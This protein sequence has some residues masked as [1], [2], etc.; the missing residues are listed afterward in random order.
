VSSVNQKDSLK[1]CSPVSG[2][3]V[4][5]LACVSRCDERSDCTLEARL[6]EFVEDPCPNTEKYLEAHYICGSKADFLQESTTTTTPSLNPLPPWLTTKSS[7]PFYPDMFD[8]EITPP[9]RRVPITAKPLEKDTTILDSETTTEIPSTT[10][11][12][13][14]TTTFAPSTTTVLVETT[15]QTLDNS[16]SSKNETSQAKI[17]KNV[18]NQTKVESNGSEKYRYSAE[19]TTN[20]TVKIV[21]STLSPKFP[22]ISPETGKPSH[23]RSDNPPVQPGK[24]SPHT[25]TNMSI[26]EHCQPRKIRALTWEW[27]VAGSEAVLECPQGTT[28]LATWKC[29]SVTSDMGTTA[30]WETPSPNL[31]QCESFW[32]TKIQEDLKRSGNIVNIAQDMVQYIAANALYGGDIKSAINAIGI[33]AEKMHFQ[34]TNIPTQEQKEAVVM[35]LV[36]SVIK[37]ASIL[38]SEHMLPA[39][40]DL[41]QDVQMKFLS[42]FMRALENTG[43]LLPKAVTRDQEASISSQNILLSVKKISFRNIIRTHF[44]SRAARATRDWQDYQDSIEI[45]ALVL[46]ENMKNDVAEI[47]FLSFKNLEH[48][49]LPTNIERVIAGKEGQVLE[50][51]HRVV[52]SQVILAS[53]G[54]QKQGVVVNEPITMLFQHKSTKNVT[55]PKCVYWD[56][57]RN[58]WSGYGCSLLFTNSSHSQCSCD[59]HLSSYALVDEVEVEDSLSHMT[60]LVVVIIAITVSFI[61]LLSLVLVIIYCRKV[62]VQDHWK[63]RL[64]ASKLPCFQ[65]QET[66]SYNTNLYGG[67]PTFRG[68]SRNSSLRG[69]PNFIPKNDF[70][71]LSQGSTAGQYLGCQA[72]PQAPS[73]H[74]RNPERMSS[75]DHHQQQQYARYIQE[76]VEGAQGHLYQPS[77]QQYSGAHIYMEVDP[78]YSGIGL[79]HHSETHSEIMS[80]EPSE[81]DLVGVH[82]T[83]IVSSNSSQASSGYSTA[84][85]H[86]IQ[87]NTPQPNQQAA[88]FILSATPLSRGTASV[89]RSA[90]GDHGS[91][92]QR[93]R[94]AGTPDIVFSISQ[95]VDQGMVR[96]HSLGRDRKSAVKRANQLANQSLEHPLI[97]LEESQII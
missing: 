5:I 91:A 28:G 37:S 50:K 92:G 30:R 23:T 9:P 53:M 36:Q 21:L 2:T 46:M 61:T 20:D 8:L 83:E 17:G 14:E 51:T 26:R 11:T 84:P 87:G 95:G 22:I 67:S 79:L 54:H 86:H 1:F 4:V 48:L 80:S 39:W 68:R 52:N 29:A 42:N 73:N 72:G 15:I 76:G 65:K 59:G 16:Y 43:R 64:A 31:G 74:M 32:M 35:E 81:E 77:S 24:V 75:I 18:G 13:I 56:F 27:T 85:S 10:Q 78:I 63:K 82:S 38:L 49:L 45:P 88:P 34:L 40:Q 12:V 62:K 19:N 97:R 60:F 70:M 94:H 71:V 41:E 25:N 89:L 6:D 96:R 47:V 33:I 69:T 55:N 57:T 3:V 66:R 58:A 93:Q 44:P 7:I 90:Y